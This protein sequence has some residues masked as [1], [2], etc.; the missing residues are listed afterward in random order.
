MRARRDKVLAVVEHDEQL[1]VLDMGGE[2]FDQR[3]S[4]LVAH[5]EDLRGDAR[6]QR[7]IAD[8][9]QID[10]PDA[11]RKV[12]H[13][14]GGDLQRQPRL[15]ETAH[16]QQ[17]QQPRLPEQVLGVAELALAPDER[18][19]LLRKIVRRRLERAQRRKILLDFRMHEL[20]DMLGRGKVAQPD[21]A[22][23]AQRD[24]RRKMI[25]HLIDDGLRHQRLPAVRGFHDPRGAV[26]GTAE[27][28]VVPP[29]DDPEMQAEANAQPDAA[30]RA[31]VLKRL[32]QRQRRLQRIRRGVERGIHPVPGH[33]DDNAAIA[34][35]RLPR[36]RIMPRE[37]GRHRLPLLF[38]EAGASF[39]VGEEES[40]DA[41]GHLDPDVR[42][43]G[44][45][46]TVHFT[47]RDGMLPTLRPGAGEPRS[48]SS[49]N[50]RDASRA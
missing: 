31:R 21:A 35:D 34:L 23:I 20:I 8:R 32:E 7:R 42:R 37:R 3:P 40:R 48:Y 43:C 49:R 13:Q 33:L 9:R 19:D 17:R 26:D 5:R 14:V 6:N 50:C 27:D 22:Q 1:A 18:R 12:L 10:E 46:A 11:I 36:Q 16:P 25:A 28:V 15:A 44:R 45:P 30:R 38:P 39:D 29:F 4:R 47:A 24:R 41:G 2:R